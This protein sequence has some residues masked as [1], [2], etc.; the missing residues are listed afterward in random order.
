MNVKNK[1]LG[2]RQEIAISSLAIKKEKTLS[3]YNEA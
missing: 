1:I 2:Y 3:Q